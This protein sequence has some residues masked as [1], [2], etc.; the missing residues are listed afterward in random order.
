MGK[1]V[2]VCLLALLQPQEDTLRVMFWNLENFFDYRNDSTSVS[3]AE[4]SSFGERR[5]TRKRFNAKCNAIAKGILWA[6]S[7]EGGLP[8]VIGF[9]EVENA[10]VLRRLLQETALR[11]LDY[12]YVHFDSPD[13][14]GID[15]ALLYRSSRLKLEDA[16]PCHLFQADTV[17][18][19][20]DILLCR[21]SGRFGPFSVLVNHHPSKYGGTTVSEPRRRLAVERLR[22]LADSLTALGENRIIATGD[23]NDTPANPVYKLLEPCFVPRAVELFQSGRGTIKYDGAWNLIDMFYVSPALSSARMSILYIPFLQVPDA[24]HGGTKPLR[25]YTGPRYTGGV[26]DHCPV[27][28]TVPLPP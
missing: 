7:A 16:R 6:G 18:A 20:R 22:F 13:S 25:T 27:W 5:W 28:L 9:A 2:L 11:K 12:K 1:M 24:A 15:V 17:M 3:D 10:F 21:F 4:F 23:F 19:T 26:S 14:R 8:D